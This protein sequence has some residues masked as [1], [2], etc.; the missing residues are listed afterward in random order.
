M[1]IA[2]VAVLMVQAALNEVVGVIA[3]RHGG[4]A[5]LR[6]VNVASLVTLVSMFRRAAVRVVVADLDRVLINAVAV[7]V[8]QMAIVKIINMVAVL[9]CDVSTS[10]TVMMRM[11]GGG[12]MPVGG[13]ESFL[14]P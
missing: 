3:V 4:V 12:K 7:R 5:A 1:V 9:D 11:F 14:S 8:M 13:H 2:V 10:M 6:T